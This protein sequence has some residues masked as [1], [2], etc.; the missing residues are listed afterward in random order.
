M[1]INGVA[2]I[3]PQCT[4]DTNDFL[5]DIIECKRYL[6]C[7]E[8][9][10]KKY[11]D[12]KKLRRMSRIMRIG[13]T[14]AKYCLD[15]AGIEQPDAIFV[16]T[17]LGCLKDTEKFL[18][19]MLDYNEKFL[20]PTSFIQS[21]HNTI[22]AQI[23][24]ML[25]NYNDNITFVHENVSFESSLINAYMYISEGRAKNILIGGIDEITEDYYIKKKQIS[26]W[27]DEN[28]VNT[29]LYMS[30]TVGT[31]PGEGGAFFL[32]SDKKNE[33]T[34]S[35]MLAVDVVYKLNGIND[36]EKRFL[37]ILNQN[38][39]SLDDI[40]LV[41]LGNNGD[42]DND[43]IYYQLM[44]SIFRNKPLA[45][46][47]HLCGEYD[48]SSAFGFWLGTMIIKNNKV[49]DHLLISQKK[50]DKLQNIVLYNQR[51]NTNHSII[52]LSKQ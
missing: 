28:V 8:P 48:T 1:F 52:I 42:V 50:P 30:K 43:K 26:A 37:K 10:Y 13:M 45:Y 15:S 16:G 11:I 35:Q 3:S 22:G 12:A 41:I 20:N 38:N 23:S 31:M 32:V 44:E 2:N 19:T 4:F 7:K 6:T 27:K 29:R 17:G 33:I 25:K 14:S 36:L 24:L 49:P 34:Y 40:D 5:T 46:Y 21:T 51:N 47:K 18:N 39:L 9:E